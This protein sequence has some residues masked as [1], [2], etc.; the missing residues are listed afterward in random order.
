SLVVGGAAGL[1]LPA[2]G[3]SGCATRSQPAGPV[4]EFAQPTIRAGDRWTYVEI[5]RYNQLPLAQVEVTVTNL[6]PLTC[7]VR[8]TR[9]DATAGE[10]A[11]PDAIQEER[12]AQPWT[13]EVEPTYDLTMEFA[14]PMPILP[15]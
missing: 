7:S 2:L 12:Y 10:I 6:S 5:N 9:S 8:R 3:L 11:R 13:V 1:L 14:E 4:R 15:A